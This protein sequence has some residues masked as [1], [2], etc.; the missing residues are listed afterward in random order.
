MS[1]TEAEY[2]AASVAVRDAIFLR[3]LLEDMNYVQS[4]MNDRP[5]VVG[6]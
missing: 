4:Y 3:D 5:G 2:F 6:R 1:S